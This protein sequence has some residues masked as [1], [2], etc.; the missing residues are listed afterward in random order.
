MTEDN[1]MDQPVMMQGTD[2]DMGQGGVMDQY[3][4]QYAQQTNPPIPPEL[5]QLLFRGQAGMKNGS[6]PNEFTARGSWT[7]QE[8]EQLI[9][10][11]QQLGPKKWIDIAKFV[12]TRTSKQCRERWHHRLDPQIKHEPFEAWED[13]LIIEKQREIGNRWAV[14]AHQ[15]P[16]RSASAIK[17]RWY[18][19]LKSQHPTHAQMD[20]TMGMVAL[21][22]QQVPSLDPTEQEAGGVMGGASTDL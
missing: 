13:Q 1:P 2:A 18:S 6:Q 19:G 8:D 12:P 22:Q 15:L 16:G 4:A 14:I 7:Q 20:I 5:Y 3:A 17:N 11:V 21:Q 10:A 9:A